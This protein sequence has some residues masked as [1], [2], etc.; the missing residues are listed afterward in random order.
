MTGPS[1]K[2]PEMEPEFLSL[3]EFCSK[4]HRSRDTAL[5]ML[6]RGELP[7][8]K[9]GRSIMIRIRDAQAWA[10]SLPSFRG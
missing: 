6:R 4:Y 1:R 3:P 8:V 7:A 5:R 2:T 10:D 9:A